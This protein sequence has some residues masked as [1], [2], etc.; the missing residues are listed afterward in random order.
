VKGDSSQNVSGQ[1]NQKSDDKAAMQQ[2][3]RGTSGKKSNV[4]ALSNEDGDD[5][6]DNQ[7]SSNKKMF[8]DQLQHEV[9][10]QQRGNNVN[11]IPSIGEELDIEFDND[12]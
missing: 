10:A 6:D 9:Q 7:L 12:I 8:M 11:M 1:K 3:D 4:M 2:R 5:Y